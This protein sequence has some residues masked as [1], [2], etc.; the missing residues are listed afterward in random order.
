VAGPGVAVYW[1]RGG[2]PAGVEAEGG[3]FIGRRPDAAGSEA[4]NVYVLGEDLR[5][6]GS[7]GGPYPS[8]SRLHARVDP[9][10]GDT[11]IIRDHG[12]HGE[13]S[14]NGTYVNGA[15]LPRGGEAVE[16]GAALVRLSSQGPVVLVVRPGWR[17][18]EAERL[19]SSPEA[20][21]CL[22]SLLRSLAP[23]AAEPGAA[24]A[25]G[26]C[27]YLLQALS[28]VN[29]A[30]AAA[31][32]GSWDEAEHARRE[33][34]RLL[35]RGEARRLLGE[36]LEGYLEGGVDSLLI[37]VDTGGAALYERILPLVREKLR[38]AAAARGCL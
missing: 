25:P 1:C 13:G 35:E 30:L 27:L 3:V 38:E 20:P 37:A 26:E 28:R 17:G 18:E 29:E 4:Y 22:R 5:V 8:V 21:G 32:R 12:P 16:R 14:T 9:G 6:L 19:L 7:I 34:R 24:E 11:I 10:P 36:Q 23:A 15:R 2:E 33:L 31:S